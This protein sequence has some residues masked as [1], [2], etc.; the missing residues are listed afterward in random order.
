[1]SCRR[2]R[3]AAV[4]D[5]DDDDFEDRLIRSA[6]FEHRG[7]RASQLIGHGRRDIIGRYR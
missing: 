3:I 5:D 4:G 6:R 2:S 7:H 1:M